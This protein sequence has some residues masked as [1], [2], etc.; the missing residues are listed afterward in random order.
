MGARMK[1]YIIPVAV[2]IVLLG[3]IKLAD[4]YLTKGMADIVAGNYLAQFHGKHRAI[5]AKYEKIYAGQ[6]QQI[7][8]LKARGDAKDAQVQRDVAL[9]TAKAKTLDE[10]NARLRACG[11]YILALPI[12]YRGEMDELERQFRVI[13]KTKD[14]EM[15][16]HRDL[17]Q[18][19]VTKLAHE[20]ARL[21]LERQKRLVIGPQVGYGPSGIYVGIGATIDIGLRFRTPWNR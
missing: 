2:G 3:A 4:R 14:T 8:A 10:A 7:A 17:S 12:Y 13:I 20:V 21:Q 9:L 19:A 11:E 18:D 15:K 6:E 1:K 5:H 16:E